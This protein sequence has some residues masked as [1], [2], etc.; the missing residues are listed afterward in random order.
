MYF[1][2]AQRTDTMLGIGGVAGCRI[3]TQV[4]RAI[5]KFEWALA[6]AER[7]QQLT[8]LVAA[9]ITPSHS[10]AELHAPCSG[11]GCSIF[12]QPRRSDVIARRWPES[13]RP[14]RRT[15]PKVEQTLLLTERALIC[16]AEVGSPN[17]IAFGCNEAC[18]NLPSARIYIKDTLL[19][20]GIFL[21]HQK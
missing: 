11:A 8:Q 12:C 15:A 3:R 19:H 4:L 14:R 1:T 21:C 7:L 10:A 17:P 13:R 18:R 2:V 20:V 9:S 16:P 5:E 6:A